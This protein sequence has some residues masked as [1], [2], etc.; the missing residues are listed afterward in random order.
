M[1]FIAI[2]FNIICII[3]IIMQHVACFPHH[4]SLYAANNIYS[5]ILYAMCL[6]TLYIQYLFIIIH[7]TRYIFPVIRAYNMC[8]RRYCLF[9]GG[10]TWH[11]RTDSEEGTR[12][13]WGTLLRGRLAGRV[14]ERLTK[15]IMTNI[16]SFAIVVLR[17]SKPSYQQRPYYAALVSWH[18]AREGKSN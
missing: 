8:W 7:G 13:L 16:Y 12:G 5:T 2:T 11:E 17:L 15:T 14:R 3:C 10:W 18:T 6:C 4:I 1:F 9:S